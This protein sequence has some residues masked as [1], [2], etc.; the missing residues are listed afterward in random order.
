VVLLVFPGRPA[1]SPQGVGTCSVGWIDDGTEAVANLVGKAER[2][3][4][5]GASFLAAAALIKPDVPISGIR[6]TR[7]L[8]S[9][10]CAM[11]SYRSFTTSADRGRAPGGHR[12]SGPEGLG[13]DADSDDA[14]C[15][16]IVQARTSSA[17]LKLLFIP[18]GR[19]PNSARVPATW[20]GLSGSSIDL[21]TPAVLDHPGEPGRCLC[22]LLRDR[23]QVSPSC[24]GQ[25]LPTCNNE[26]PTRSLA[27]RLT[28]SPS[29]ARARWLP[30]TTPGRLHGGRAIPMVGTFQLTRSTRLLLTH[31]C[32]ATPTASQ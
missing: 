10:A 14:D 1:R 4:S 8:S 13:T 7:I 15:S 28:P 3:S 24:E 16:A 6:L 12:T 29:Q 17:F 27:L 32:T 31:A 22:S 25:P 30:I 2:S 18:A 9:Q 21:S 26:A 5:G 20:P 19:W 23:F 11:A